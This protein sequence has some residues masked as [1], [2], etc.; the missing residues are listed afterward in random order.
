MSKEV[1]CTGTGDL[2]IESTMIFSPARK[3][4]E[5]SGIGTL[6]VIV[7]VVLVIVVLAYFGMGG[8]HFHL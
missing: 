4:N 7:V 8:L 1:S 2:K 3:K 6:G 5:R